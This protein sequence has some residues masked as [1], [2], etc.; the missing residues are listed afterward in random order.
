[1]DWCALQGRTRRSLRGR[2]RDNNKATKVLEVSSR[3]GGGWEEICNIPEPIV[4]NLTI[5][6]L[7]P[8]SF[9]LPLSLVLSSSSASQGARLNQRL[10]LFHTVQLSGIWPIATSITCKPLWLL[11][12]GFSFLTN[13]SERI[14]SSSGIGFHAFEAADYAQ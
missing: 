1:M 14:G 9:C 7:Q 4:D 12:R 10:L 11:S 13:Q 3:R 6:T 8:A 5:R 2:G